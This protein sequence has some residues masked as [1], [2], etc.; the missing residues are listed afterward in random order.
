MK[1]NKDNLSEEERKIGQDTVVINDDDIVER[2]S[3]LYKALLELS[4]DPPPESDES[5]PLAETDVDF[6]D[7]IIGRDLSEDRYIVRRQVNRG[8]MGILFSVYDR[9]FQRHSVM[10]VLRPDVKK[11]N[12]LLRT[13]V[14]EARITAQLEHPNIVPV[15]DLGVMSSEGPY[16]TMKHVHGESLS[17]IIAHLE[18][19]D[20]EYLEKYDTT[21]MLEIFRKVCDALSFAH[22][23]N[24]I[25]R[26][27]KPQNIMVG[28]F[29]EVYLMDWGLGKKIDVKTAETKLSKLLQAD[30]PAPGSVVLKGSPGYMSPEQAGKGSHTLDKRSDIF[31]LGATLYHMFTFFPPYIGTSIASILNA[32]RSCDYLPPED[33]CLS[34]TGMPQEL[35]RIINKC[36][37][38][39]KSDRYQSIAELVEDID[40]LIYGRMES[41]YRSLAP[42]ELLIH[43]GD[44]GD[45]CYIIESGSIMIYKGEGDDKVILN[46]L[47]AGDIL[48]EMALITKDVRSASAEALEECEV[49]IMDNGLFQRNLS[50]LPPWMNN[51]I[52]T[53]AQRL[54]RSDG[55]LTEIKQKKK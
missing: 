51:A 32:A 9:D 46:T 48:G 17:Q 11:D 27:V 29:G 22:A 34:P 55:E 26:D 4:Q 20:P 47:G 40:A 3:S 2:Y 21:E 15:H 28:D 24:I 13:F 44:F 42:G 7:R 1:P 33:L 49:L 30:L 38:P 10:K 36:M 14:R 12:P 16:F 19:E 53:L 50:R 39:E 43:E 52:M 8:G 6:F 37:A 35:C 54:A 18:K 5:E 45:E 41:R 23:K 25:H 31:L